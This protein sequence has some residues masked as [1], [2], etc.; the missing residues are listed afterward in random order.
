MRAKTIVITGAS[1]GIG[2]AA[3][4]SFCRAGFT[5]FGTVRKTADGERLRT[6][7]GD[8][9][10]PL[11]MDVTDEAAVESAVETVRT[12]LGNQGLGGLINNAGIAIGG[13]LQYQPMAEIER[14]FE[15]NIFGLLRVTKAFLPLLGAEA[16]YPYTPGKIINIGSVGGRVAGPFVGAYA[17]TKHAL[18]G[19]TASL[20]R[21]LLLYGI[22]VILVGPGSVATPIWDK[23]VDPTP[24]AETDYFDA[25]HRFLRSFVKGGRNGMPPEEIGELLL[26][27]QTTDRPKVRYAPV[28]D[29]FK[30]Y[31]LPRL[32]PA[33]MLDRMIGKGI[34]PEKK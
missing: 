18:E 31:T 23:G 14:H 19:I 5:V 33:R 12:V 7:L 11:L 32:L 29:K 1:T 13:P 17:G 25:L 30:R 24:Y 2:Y 16:D 27:I 6:E 3:A 22:D 8:H 15:V 21:E 10:H 28:K 26:H 20:R 4:Q 9:I 34:Y